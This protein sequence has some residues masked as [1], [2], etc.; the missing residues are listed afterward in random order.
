MKKTATVDEILDNWESEQYRDWYAV[1][2]LMAQ[3][4]KKPGRINRLMVTSD[5]ARAQD[6]AARHAA[7]YDVAFG[8]PGEIGQMNFYRCT[9]ISAKVAHDYLVGLKRGYS[10]ELLPMSE[11]A[12]VAGI[13]RQA[14]HGRIE[15]STIPAELV[16]R[17]W[18]V[19][20]AS[21]KIYSQD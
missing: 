7:G 21:V 11:A 14:M 10:S 15:R 5:K 2:C 13:S 19:L 6:F 18:Y 16:G 4:G 20:A 12:K 1:D 9:I 3:D 17:E 8:E